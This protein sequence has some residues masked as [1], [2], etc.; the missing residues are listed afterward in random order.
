MLI[1]AI[2]PISGIYEQIKKYA[3]AVSKDDRFPKEKTKWIFILLSTKLN[4][5]AMSECNQVDRDFGH[6]D[7]KENYD[8]YVKRW[9]DL[10]NEAEGRHQYLK[11]KLNYTVTENEEGIKLLK[12]KYA[13][14]LPDEVQ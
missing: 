14:Y 5:D 12:Q 9:G 2:R 11:T 4:E 8:V 3:R 7:T 6:I 13:E 10:L 1:L